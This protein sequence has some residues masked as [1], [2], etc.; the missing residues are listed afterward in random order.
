[1]TYSIDKILGIVN[2][3]YQLVYV[4]AKRAT[5]MDETKHYQMK[6]KDYKAKKSLDRALEEVQNGLI[7]VN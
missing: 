4:A 1:M 7:H 5:Q 6:E 3:K 2:S